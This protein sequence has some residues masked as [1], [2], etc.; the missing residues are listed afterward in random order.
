M[1]LKPVAWLGFRGQKNAFHSDR[2]WKRWNSRYAGAEAFTTTSEDGYRTGTVGGK[3]YRAHRVIWL[4]Q[5]GAWP[6]DEIDHR[7]GKRSDNRWCNLRNATKGENQRNQRRRT[8]NSSGATGVRWHKRDGKW[9]AR[10][11]VDGAYRH[12]GRFD[13]KEEAVRAREKAN[14]EL[15]FT[16][17]H[18][19]RSPPAAPALAIVA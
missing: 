4:I 6:A 9:E 3:T 12:L 16:E 2:E 14:S 8:D 15:G 5:T 19:T 11:Q 18:G 10:L 7:N 13:T 1:T 17:R